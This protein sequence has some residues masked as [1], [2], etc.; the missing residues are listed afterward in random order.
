LISA[1]Q[2]PGFEGWPSESSNSG[3][4]GGGEE[5]TGRSVLTITV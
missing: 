5:L 4:P 3:W 1:G 2:V